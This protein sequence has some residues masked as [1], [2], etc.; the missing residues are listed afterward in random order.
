[1]T[2]ILVNNLALNDKQRKVSNS[3][4]EHL[5]DKVGGLQSSPD[6]IRRI[7]V[8]N[9]GHFNVCKL[10][11]MWG[12][13]SRWPLIVLKK[14][15][16]FPL[17]FMAFMSSAVLLAY[18]FIVLCAFL[19]KGEFDWSAYTS[20][21]DSNYSWSKNT[22]LN[23]KTQILLLRSWDCDGKNTSEKHVNFPPN[24]TKL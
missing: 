5:F 13:F 11:K 4:I 16:L 19:S 22:T 8:F 10:L 1:M 2:G 12:L 9:K 20:T 17:K 18:I 15:A 3:Q 21:G 24:E 7:F 14:I 23:F 6:Q